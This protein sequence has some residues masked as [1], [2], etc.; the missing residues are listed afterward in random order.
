MR[1]STRISSLLG[2]IAGAIL[3]LFGKSPAGPAVGDLKRADFPTSTQRLG[4]RFSEKIRDAFRCKWLRV[5]GK[6]HIQDDARM[7]QSEHSGR[8]Q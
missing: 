7:E 1:F 6:T 3:S 4:I 2:F 8:I 5:T